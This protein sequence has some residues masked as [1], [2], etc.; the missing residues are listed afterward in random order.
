MKSIA[1]GKT[2]ARKST[3]RAF[4]TLTKTGRTSRRRRRATEDDTTEDNARSDHDTRSDRNMRSDRDG[5]FDHDEDTDRD[6]RFDRD[7]DTDETPAMPV[8]P[9]VTSSNLKRRHTGLFVS[10]FVLVLLPVVAAAIYLMVFAEDQYASTVGFTIRQEES[11]GA[12]ELMG[13]LSRAFGGGGGQGHTDLLFEF[14]QSQDIVERIWTQFD[15][16]THYSATWDRD[17]AFSIWPEATIE[18]MVWFWRRMVKVIY[19][20]SS[21][22]LLIEVRARDPQSAQRIAQLIVSESEQMINRLNSVARADSMRLAEEDLEASLNRLREAREALAQFRARTQIVDPQA[23][24]QGRMGVM[25][26]LQQQLAIALIDHDLLSQT[27]DANDPRLRQLDRRIE[28]V[29]HRIAQER[30]SFTRL[31]VTF[32]E[33]DYPR[34]IAQFESLQVDQAFAE[35]TYQAALTA[36]DAARSNAARQNLYLANFIQPTIAQ[37]A[38]YPRTYLLIFLTFLFATMIWGVLSLVYYSLRDR[39]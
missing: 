9:T 27:A 39:G 7:E 18:D 37:R 28:A 15:L 36:M 5:R 31:D 12:S 21:G 2:L 14:V 3:K 8:R 4:S 29:R 26:N 11:S 22:M 16:V 35:A 34:L 6:G 33:T 10:M 25:N 32:D 30:E 20:K 23:D 38:Q 24:I 19:D 1:G 13:G 17:P